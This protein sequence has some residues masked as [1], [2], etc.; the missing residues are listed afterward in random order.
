VRLA[1]GTDLDDARPRALLVLAVIEVADEHVAADQAAGA[2]RDDRDA[3]W[4]LVVLGR[5][6]AGTADAT[7]SILLRRSRKAVPWAR[8]GTATAA[9][10]AVV[11]REI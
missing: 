10:A 11:M 2:P 3:V 7:V 5:P 4:I 9:A 6:R 8:A 1:T